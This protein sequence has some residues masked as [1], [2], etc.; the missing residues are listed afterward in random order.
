MKVIKWGILGTARIAEQ[1]LIPAIKQA[2]R[3]ELA[4]AASR[5]EKRAKEFMEAFMYS[6][7]SAMEKSQRIAAVR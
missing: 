2:G 1:Q 4:A 6:I 3:A 5:D 7:S